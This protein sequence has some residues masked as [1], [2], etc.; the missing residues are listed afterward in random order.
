MKNAKKLV[1]ITTSI[2]IAGM[3][4]LYSCKSYTGPGKRNIFEEGGDYI[5][6]ANFLS[7]EEQYSPMDPDSQARVLFTNEC[8]IPALTI[9]SRGTLIAA[10]GCGTTKGKLIGKRSSD[11]GKNWTEF[12]AITE[13]N[14]GDSHVHPFF[15]NCHNGDILLGISTTNEAQNNVIFYRSNTDGSSWSKET[16]TI[17]MPLSSSNQ[18]GTK[19]NP[20]YVFAT[21]GNGLTL[22]HGTNKALL[23]PYF[24]RI[25]HSQANGGG[26]TSTMI[27][28]DGGKTWNQHG[29]DY[30]DFTQNEAKFIELADGKVIINFRRGNH[31]NQ[32]YWV[33]SDDLGKTWKKLNTE[34][35]DTTSHVDFVRYEFNGKDIKPG[36]SGSKYALMVYSDRKRNNYNA[37]LS[38]NDFNNGLGSHAGKHLY[39]KVVASNV[40]SVGN[41]ENIYPAITVLPDGTI[42]TLAEETN[43]MVFRRFN[44]SWLT[45]SSDGEDGEEYIDYDTDNILK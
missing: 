39:D 16:G 35:G 7:Q 38:V 10:V 17:E 22:R 44:L 9:S 27:S 2:I 41:A 40:A 33:V 5:L 4:I 11:F 13:N 24:Y 20:K 34:T 6:P 12:T 18:D 14:F 21:Y 19:F 29:A 25:Q 45:S 31:L 32:E 36:S 15:I 30:G 28:T 37:T 26:L 3:I 8:K 43:N 1:L 42:A 23:F